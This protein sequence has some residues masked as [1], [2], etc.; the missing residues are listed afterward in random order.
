MKDGASRNVEPATV[1]PPR[2]ESQQVPAQLFHFSRAIR[3]F[4]EV[5]TM[6]ESLIEGVAN[7]ARISRVG[8]F[9]AARDGETYRLRAGLKCLE[10][11]DNL[12]FSDDDPAVCWMR[13]NP[14][15]VSRSA[16][17]HID[18]TSQAALLKQVLD[19]LGAEVVI[20]LH[21][22]GRIMGWLFFGRRVMG[23]PFGEADL[24]ELARLAEHVSVILENGL[25]Y[26][27]IGLQKTLAETLLHS[28][29]AGIV[30]VDDTGC[31]SRFNEA[32]ES[33]LGMSS[34]DVLHQPAAVIGSQFG[35]L[36]VR[37]A[38]GEPT[39][40]KEWTDPVDKRNLLLQTRSLTNEGKCLGAVL[41]IRDVTEERIL[42]AKQGKIERATFWTELA[43]AISHEVRNPLVAISTFAQL[44]PERYDDP[45]FRQNFSVL[46][47]KEIGRLNKLLDQINAFANPPGLDFQ[48]LKI[49]DILQKSL[50]V[51]RTRTE[52]DG[53]EVKMS[54]EPDLP[55][56]RGDKVSLID[57]F[58]HLIT[59]S[60]EAAE[61]SQPPTV[62]VSAG[63]GEAEDGN[64][65]VCVRVVDNGN[66]IPLEI[67]EKIFS[68]FCSMKARGIGLGLPI[69]KRTVTDH[70]GKMTIE[71]SEEGTTVAVELPTGSN[72]EQNLEVQ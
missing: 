60:V 62:Q 10:G 19:T 9:A 36:L 28:M 65:G 51:A 68:P 1:A 43:A 15:L 23:L 25:L 6:L 72:P 50:E 7:C 45:E 12:E 42:H 48:P 67:S 30:A 17:I 31:I 32:A 22:G 56:V 70:S 39:E 63:Q 53:A 27:E 47:Q 14:Q 8:V 33:I 5:D 69:V 41:V 46:A 40:R 57:C 37:C 34:Q 58:A 29:P 55:P 61:S 2:E 44:L 52:F 38:R 59:N 16:L 64:K 4:D 35:D 24:E 71:T 11:T 20:P 18:D 13:V 66:G 3:H 54:A 21:G 49:G 26:G